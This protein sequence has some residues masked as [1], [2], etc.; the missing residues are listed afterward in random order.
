MFKTQKVFDCQEMPDDVREV[1][2]SGKYQ[3]ND[4]YVSHEVFQEHYLDDND[5]V[6]V[7]EEFSIV[8]NWLLDNGAFPG[9]YVLISH[10]W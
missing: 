8:D 3:G 9:E 2:F 4:C 10:W 5:Q 7:S 1:F 6:Q